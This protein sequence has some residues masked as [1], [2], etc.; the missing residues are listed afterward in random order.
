MKTCRVVWCGTSITAENHEP[1]NGYASLIAAATTIN[2]QNIAV[3]SSTCD[4]GGQLAS[5]NALYDATKEV[6]VCWVEFG[7]NDGLTKTSTQFLSDLATFVAGLNAGFTVM[8]ATMLPCGSYGGAQAFREA[9]NPAIVA[10]A[11][12][13]Y[14]DYIVNIGSTSTT[15]GAEAAKNDG[16][17]YSDTVHP[18]VA[19]YALLKPEIQRVLELFTLSLSSRNV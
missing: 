9:I 17:L 5:A 18:T 12:S 2:S 14:G 7:V 16:S 3:P 6:N 8:T 13:I 11:G 19:G 4:S 15:M 1:G 10:N